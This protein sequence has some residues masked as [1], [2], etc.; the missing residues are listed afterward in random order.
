MRLYRNGT[1]YDFWVEV[2][3]DFNSL[4]LTVL[5]CFKIKIH[6]GEID[7]YSLKAYLWT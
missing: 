7:K 2:T 4:S 3:G 6:Q 5:E 1:G